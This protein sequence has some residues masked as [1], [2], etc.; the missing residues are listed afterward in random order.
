ME[1][2]TRGELLGLIQKALDQSKDL[3]DSYPPIHN[4]KLA[5]NTITNLL[6][7]SS[8]F[9]NFRQLLLNRSD[10][11]VGLLAAKG[12]DFFDKKTNFYLYATCLHMLWY[13]I[14]P[15]HFAS[16]G[17]KQALAYKFYKKHGYEDARISSHFY[18]IDFYKPVFIRLLLKPRKVYQWRIKEDEKGDYFAEWK[19]AKPDCLGISSYKKDKKGGIHKRKK[20]IY[21]VDN[22]VEVLTSYAA[23]VLDWWSLEWPN[24]IQTSGGCVQYFNH[25]DK[26]SF[27]QISPPP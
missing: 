15:L 3:P 19:K 6:K 10:L 12:L 2:N 20:Y 4:S 27:I 23:S 17:A 25:N 13:F 9:F 8:D 1:E 24:F 16:F 5:L 7:D 14:F 26:E 18:G 21:D 22:Q 11:N